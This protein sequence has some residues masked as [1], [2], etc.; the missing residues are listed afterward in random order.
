MLSR[1][2]LLRTASLGTD[3][4]DVRCPADFVCLGR[5]CCSPP[6]ASAGPGPF[7]SSRPSR[8]M[9]EVACS[10]CGVPTS[11]ANG[12][13]YASPGL[14]FNVRGHRDRG[15]GYIPGGL[16]GLLGS[17]SV[18]KCSMFALHVVVLVESVH[19]VLRGPRSLRLVFVCAETGAVCGGI[20]RSCPGW[21]A[22]RRISDRFGS[23]DFR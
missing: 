5:L 15:V 4:A 9:G 16:P 10:A 23:E 8:W 21:W 3:H 7:S 1:N 18:R 11:A 22:V 19:L 17:H 2:L 13:S 20:V 14:V 6:G 12:Y